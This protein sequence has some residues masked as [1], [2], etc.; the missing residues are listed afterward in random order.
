[1]TSLDGRAAPELA[2]FRPARF[3]GATASL[4]PARPA[5]EQ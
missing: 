3:A 4:I 5:R 1:M 2:G